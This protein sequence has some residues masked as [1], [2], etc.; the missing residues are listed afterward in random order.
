[1]LHVPSRQRRIRSWDEN[2]SNKFVSLRVRGRVM[3]LCETTEKQKMAQ[4]TKIGSKT[5]KYFEQRKKTTREI[6]VTN[7]FIV[8]I[9]DRYVIA[10]YSHGNMLASWILAQLARADLA[11]IGNRELE[12]WRTFSHV[13]NVE[14][15]LKIASFKEKFGFVLIIHAKVSLNACCWEYRYTQLKSTLLKISIEIPRNQEWHHGQLQ[16]EKNTSEKAFSTRIC[17]FVAVCRRKQKQ[18]NHYR[19]RNDIDIVLYYWN[20][21]YHHGSLYKEAK[22]CSRNRWDWNPQATPPS[23]K[24]DLRFQVLQGCRDYAEKLLLFDGLLFWWREERWE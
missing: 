24:V 16:R 19:Q 5:R 14:R 11:R 9:M 20:Y 7:I 18:D 15:R 1:M 4:S 8:P 13:C 12:L 21:L 2:S 23:W 3:G 17:L 6:L 22:Y 10:W